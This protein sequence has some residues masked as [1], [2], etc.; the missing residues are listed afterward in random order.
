MRRLALPLSRL[1]VLF[2]AVRTAGLPLDGFGWA[3]FAEAEFLAA[4]TILGGAYSSEFPLFLISEGCSCGLGGGLAFGDV[5]SGF[6]CKLGSFALV[7]TCVACVSWLG[8]DEGELEGTTYCTRTRGNRRTTAVML[9]YVNR[10]VRGVPMP[11]Q[12]GYS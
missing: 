11:A 4:L 3:V 2:G 10:F 1:T 6:G 9:Y 12:L 5:R 7:G 8:E